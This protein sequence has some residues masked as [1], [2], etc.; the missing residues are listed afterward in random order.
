M[1]PT[2]LCL[3]NVM[4][5]QKDFL[6]I[7]MLFGLLLMGLLSV[8]GCDTCSCA[9][10]KEVVNDT[11]LLKRAGSLVEKL[12]E[13]KESSL[14]YSFDHYVKI[15]GEHYIA[16]NVCGAHLCEQAL[17]HVANPDQNP[18]RALRNGA[19]WRGAELCNLRYEWDIRS[20]WFEFISVEKIID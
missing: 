10:A 20:G 17:L 5:S 13:E 18:I 2:R 14:S 19:G 6:T 3:K 1:R 7:K 8:A 15:N 11:I 12:Y 4:V 16:V 9:S